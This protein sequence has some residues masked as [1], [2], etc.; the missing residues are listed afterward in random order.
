MPFSRTIGRGLR[1][2]WT[3]S[4]LQH[5]DQRLSKPCRRSRNANAG[6]FHRSDL[7][8]GIPLAAGDDRSGVAHAAA[9]RGGASGNEADH[10]LLAAALGLVLDELRGVFFRG[11]ADLA[12]HDDGFGRRIGQEQFKHGDEIG[13][14]DRI[15]ADADR[16]GLPEPFCSSLINRLVGQRSRAGNDS[17]AAFLEDVAGHDSNLALSGR[18]H[19]GAIRT[20]QPRFR[21]VQ[22]AADLDRVGHRSAFVDADDQRD[23][24]IDRFA[25]R[26]RRARRR[27]INHAGI[28]TGLF[29]RFR[30]RIGHRQI[31]MPCASLSRRYAA[32]HSGAVK[33]GLLG[34]KGAVLAGKALADDLG[35]AVNQYGHYAAS[36]RV[37]ALT[38]FCA[39]SSRSSADTT[40]RP[41]SLMTFLPSSTLVP[42]SRTT[43]GTVKPT[44]RTAATTPSA[45][46]SQ[47][48]MPPKILTRIPF[49][50]GSDVMILNAAATFSLV[51]PPPTSR[52]FAGVAP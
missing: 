36:F 31:E 22:R 33:H 11:A 2:S 46:T 49:T 45:T 6:G 5:V 29:A 32:D 52:K 35:I 24:G 21:I 43:S 41:D 42:S 38:I 12:D 3:R 4:S 27:H 7:G 17:D 30:H 47:R 16:G 18:H 25:N 26:V 13:A 44:S 23:L 15:A 20:D 39:A 37:V 51:A 9:G 34:M 10:R 40:L 48:M 8:C 1:R 50:L 28:G 19:A 14:L